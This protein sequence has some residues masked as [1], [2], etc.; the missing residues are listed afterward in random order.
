VIVPA[1]AAGVV[2][3]ACPVATGFAT[4]DLHFGGQR[5]DDGN[6]AHSGTANIRVVSFEPADQFTPWHRREISDQFRRA[7]TFLDAKVDAK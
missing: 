3:I 2:P 5:E 1:A 6:T 7:F 4:V